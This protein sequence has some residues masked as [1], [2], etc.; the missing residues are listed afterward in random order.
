MKTGT[1]AFS[2]TLAAAGAALLLA[3]C[4]GESPESRLSEAG[5]Q[6]EE[7]EDDLASLKARIDETEQTLDRLRARRSNMKDRLRTLEERLAA[8]ATDVALFRAVQSAL[9]DEPGLKETAIN[10]LVEDS[11]V[12]LVGSVPSA[13]DRERALEIARNTPGAAEIRSRLRIDDPQQ[14]T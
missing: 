6:V 13:A 12:T 7:V 3:A 8:R 4:S 14:T 2:K 10:V 1:S 5:E 11:V 9:L